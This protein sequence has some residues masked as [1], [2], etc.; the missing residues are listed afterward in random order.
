MS[1]VRGIIAISEPLP[2]KEN[3]CTATISEGN[4][5]NMITTSCKREHIYTAVIRE[6]NDNNM[7]T[8]SYK[9]EKI[10]SYHQ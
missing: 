7:R 4:D 3:I 2:I 1:S 8:T 9:R 10:H 6:R 5:N